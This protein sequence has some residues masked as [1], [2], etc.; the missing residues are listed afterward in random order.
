MPPAGAQLQ[1]D[2]PQAP[3]TDAGRQPPP[4]RQR[5]PFEGWGSAIGR[6]LAVTFGAIAS[7]GGQLF[8]RARTGS[9]KAYAEFQTRPEHLRWRV[10]AFGGYGMILAATLGAQLYDGNALK[11]YVKLQRVEDVG[12]VTMIF[13]RNDSKATWKKPK[14][15]L[16][17]IYSYEKHELEPGAH[18]LL[19]V[20]RFAIFDAKGRPTYAPKSVPLET[21][22][23]ETTEGRFVTELK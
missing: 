6:A 13:V 2:A 3:A 18:M 22:A 23:V 21:I 15:V 12:G 5:R 11:A 8:R 20:N 19:G 17:G 16:N 1:H 7:I 14:I 4:A 9:S 10:Y